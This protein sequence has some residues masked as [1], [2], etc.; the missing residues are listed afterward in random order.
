VKA[1]FYKILTSEPHCNQDTKSMLTR[2][3][4]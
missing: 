2:K 3:L 4:Q 1:A